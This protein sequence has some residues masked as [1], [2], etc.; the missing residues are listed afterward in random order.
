[1]PTVQR[2]TGGTPREPKTGARD[3]QET[4]SERSVVNMKASRGPEPSIQEPPGE[5]RAHGGDF[6]QKLH[7]RARQSSQDLHRLLLSLSTGL[8]A[9]YFVALTTTEDAAKPG[10]QTVTAIIGLCAMGVA[11]FAGL[12]GLYADM[13]RNYFRGSAIQATKPTRRDYLYRKRDL[14]LRRQRWSIRA[15]NVF[16]VFGVGMS[17]VYVICRILDR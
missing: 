14:W 7:D 3:G 15:L 4:E 17:V 5:K 6:A 9:V 10:V 12:L 8:V 1:M 2:T 11:V 16:F 13:K